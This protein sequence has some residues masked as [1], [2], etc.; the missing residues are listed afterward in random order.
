ASDNAGSTVDLNAI[1]WTTFSDGFDSVSIGA[2]NTLRLG[3]FGG[4]IRNGP[5]TSHAVYV[6][7]ENSTAQSGN[8]TS[9]SGDIGT[10]TAGGPNANTPGEIVVV[11]N[12][13]SETSGTT[14]FE[15]TI[16]DNGTG[17]VTFVKMG[18]GSIKL[19]GHNTFSGGLYLLQGRVQFAGSEIGND[20]PDGGGV[21]PIFVLPG[22]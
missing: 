13:P 12:N 6:G 3:K 21:G 18:P 7:G 19:D 10:L 4:I 2:G 9:G 16:A 8:G 11:A 15:P 14:I 22:A 5:T 17:P 1:K 20:N